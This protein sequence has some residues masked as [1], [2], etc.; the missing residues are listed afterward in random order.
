[1]VF[2]RLI[3]RYDIE[4][5]ITRPLKIQRTELFCKDQRTIGFS[6]FSATCC[7]FVILLGF[8]RGLGQH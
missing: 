8:S 1:M 7:L 2:V 6:H 3:L 4:T 5:D